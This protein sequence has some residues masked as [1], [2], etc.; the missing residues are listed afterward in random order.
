M[1]KKSNKESSQITVI[2][3]RDHL[4]QNSAYRV[5]STKYKVRSALCEADFCSS[6]LCAWR[7]GS[8]S[9]SPISFAYRDSLQLVDFVLNFGI[10][11][12]QVIMKGEHLSV[13]QSC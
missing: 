7:V 8:N 10:I 6:C 3:H 4:G 12:C 13:D 11:S 1:H 5:Q 9:T 2:S